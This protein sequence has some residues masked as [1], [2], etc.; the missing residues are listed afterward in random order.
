MEYN[1]VDWRFLKFMREQLAQHLALQV[2]QKM[3]LIKLL[4]VLANLQ[5]NLLIWW[6]SVGNNIENWLVT[7]L[8]LQ[9]QGQWRI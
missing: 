4:R 7:K 2:K 8:C 5:S 1:I 6:F 3:V 9:K